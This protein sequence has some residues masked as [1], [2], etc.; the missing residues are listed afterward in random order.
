MREKYYHALF[1]KILLLSANKLILTNCT[2]RHRK[3]DK[4]LPLCLCHG[5]TGFIHT[6]DQN[7]VQSDISELMANLSLVQELDKSQG[8]A[9]EE[10][11][12]LVTSHHSITHTGLWTECTNCQRGS[13]VFEADYRGF[14]LSCYLQLCVSTFIFS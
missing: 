1:F 12:R 9:E 11:L 14:F 6:L 8:L 7:A 10:R 13:C 2:H 3:S 4:L 5:L